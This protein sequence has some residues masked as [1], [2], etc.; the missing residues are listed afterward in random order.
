MYA[1][2]R[3]IAATVLVATASLAGPA[4]AQAPAPGPNILVV[5]VPLV[6]RE[7]K[8]GK[9]IG[10]QLTQQQSV[11]QKDISTQERELAN[12]G[13]ELK[14]QEQILARDAYEARAR[15]LQQ[16]A[17]ELQRNVGGKRETLQRAEGNAFNETLKTVFAIVADIAK[18]RRATHVLI[19]SPQIVAYVD[20]QFDVT[21]EVLQRL[22]QRLPAMAVSFPPPSSGGS[23]PAGSPAPAQ[24]A[25]KGK[26]KKN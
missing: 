9:S 17:D 23:Q 21:N 12:A 3:T 5:D 2:L 22:D 10:Q 20:P 1:T 19:R 24:A 4:L 7:S 13:S 6:L 14:R 25:S 8:V 15:E 11:Y 18:E 16:R 26:A